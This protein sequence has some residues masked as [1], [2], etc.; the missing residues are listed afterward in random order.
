MLPF[1]ALTVFRRH[2]R[3]REERS[4]KQPGGSQ[5]QSGVWKWRAKGGVPA[6]RVLNALTLPRLMQHLKRRKIV[7]DR[8]A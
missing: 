7:Q 2:C 5:A 6:D 8:A 4:L 1:A 3:Q